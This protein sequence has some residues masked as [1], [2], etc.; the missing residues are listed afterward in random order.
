M[1]CGC[2]KATTATIQRVSTDQTLPISLQRGVTEDHRGDSNLFKAESLPRFT[3][4]SEFVDFYERTDERPERN[5]LMLDAYAHSDM[6][7][8][9][10]QGK[11]KATLQLDYVYGYRCFLSRQNVFYTALPDTVAYPAAALVVLLNTSSNTQGFLGG[12]ELVAAQG[13]SDDIVAMT[14]SKGR[15]LVATG[16]VGN[17][18]LICVWKLQQEGGVEIKKLEQGPDTRAVV[19]LAFSEDSKQLIAVDQAQNQTIRIYDWKESVTPTHTLAVGKGRVWTVRYSPKGSLFCAVGKE[20]FSF[21]ALK[22]H[23]YA[24]QKPGSIDP[25]VNMN[26]VQWLSNGNCVTGGSD[27]QLYLW[28]D[29]N[30]RKKY[31]VF[32]GCEILALAI[33]QDVIVLGGAGLTI[34]VLNATFKEV[35]KYQVPDWVTSVDRNGDNILCSTRNGLIQ[36]LTGNSRMVLMESHCEREV[37]SLAASPND[38]HMIISAGDDNKIKSWDL[39]QRRCVST[40]ILESLEVNRPHRSS[41]LPQSQQS[42][43]L[44]VSPKGHVAVAHNDGRIS[45]RNNIHQLNIILKLLSDPGDW[46]QTLQYSPKGSALAAGSMDTWIYVYDVSAGYSLFHKLGGLGKIVGLDWSVEEDKIRGT[47]IN[48]RVMV[49]E[50]QSETSVAELGNEQWVTW[51]SAVGQP[52]RGISQLNSDPAFITCVNRSLDSK[53]FAV[54]NAW[55]LLEIYDNPNSPGSKSNIYRGHSLEVENALWVRQDRVLLTA[56]GPDLTIMQW[57]VSDR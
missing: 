32:E 41:F 12:G 34:R 17:N 26:V 43:A 9:E 6:N 55:G 37:W 46:I 31:A 54:G 48:T 27:G 15:D 40:C 57:K 42:R 25:A 18:P 49:W 29:K 44:A 7:S 50:V 14:V 56:G 53:K 36:E 45:I 28:I 3:R 1:G 16:E 39:I 47:D 30:L 52:V 22:G 11:P 23:E 21:W 8:L 13:H 4:K 10:D 35:S 51:T 38:W 19:A 24:K 5:R 33:V 2:T 20:H